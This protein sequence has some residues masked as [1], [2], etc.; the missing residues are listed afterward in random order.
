VP[1]PHYVGTGPGISL[2][3]ARGVAA[4]IH[5]TIKATGKLGLVFL[6]NVSGAST[7]TD[8]MHGVLKPCRSRRP[9]S[10]GTLSSGGIHKVRSI[11]ART[12][13]STT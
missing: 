11:R 6:A 5:F 12:T 3:A 9:A 4:R 8:D 7:Y 2:S 1:Y 10:A 13:W